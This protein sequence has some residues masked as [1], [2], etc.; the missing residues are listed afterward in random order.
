MKLAPGAAIPEG[1]KGCY[2]PSGNN[3]YEKRFSALEENIKKQQETIEKQQRDINALLE[4]SKEDKPV[5][6]KLKVNEYKNLVS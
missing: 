6:L 3:I 1:A 4:Q 5:I 2:I